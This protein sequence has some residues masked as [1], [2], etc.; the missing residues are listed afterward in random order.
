MLQTTWTRQAESWHE[1]EKGESVKHTWAIFGAL[2]VAAGGIWFYLGSMTSPMEVFIGQEQEEQY[3]W[4]ETCRPIRLTQ[5]LEVAAIGEQG[6]KGLYCPIDSDIAAGDDGG[7]ATYR[8]HVFAAGRYR[9]WGYCCWFEEDGQFAMQAEG[10][11]TIIVSPTGELRQWQWIPLGQAQLDEGTGKIKLTVMSDGFAVR[12]LFLSNDVHCHPLQ[13]PTQI[14]DIFF[15]DFDGCDEGE[16]DSWSRIS[17]SWHVQRLQEASSPASQVLIGQSSHGAL[18]SVGNKSWRDYAILLNCRTIEASPSARAGVRFC[19]D[20][21][22]NGHVLAWTPKSG[23]RVS[24]AL[25][26]E[27]VA[28]IEVIDRFDVEWDVFRWN[29]LG[30]NVHDDRVVVSI[31]TKPVHTIHATIPKHGAIGLSLDGPIEMMYDNVQVR[32]WS[33]R[34]EVEPPRDLP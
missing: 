9:L 10:N 24:M 28:G 29:E 14:N 31:N 15:D 8:F 11:D 22:G 27:R 33:V 34:T 21:E 16:F 13:S 18:V 1:L 4:V 5:P 23:S 20:E 2:I 32:G 3:I 19:C 30:I 17:G 7:E 26:Q 12:R 25:L 6:D